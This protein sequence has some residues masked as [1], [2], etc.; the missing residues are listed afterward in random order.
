MNRHLGMFSANSLLLPGGMALSALAGMD[1]KNLPV[2]QADA[3]TGATRFKA[4]VDGYLFEDGPDV[5][6]DPHPEQD[7]TIITV[8]QSDFRVQIV[9]TPQEVIYA[10]RPVWSGKGGDTSEQGHLEFELNAQTGT[11]HVYHYW[12]RLEGLREGPA[13]TERVLARLGLI[14]QIFPVY[15]QAAKIHSQVFEGQSLG[16]TAFTHLIGLLLGLSEDAQK[17]VRND[18]SEQSVP[19]DYFVNAPIPSALFTEYQGACDRLSRYASLIRSLKPAFEHLEKIRPRET[20]EE[21]AY[22]LS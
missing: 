18:I 10:E 19:M 11:N 8:D 13:P 12:S 15:D 14:A 4:T 17:R 20:G 16:L 9:V 3:N 7:E 1:M 5:V 6:F 21:V 2:R 22:A